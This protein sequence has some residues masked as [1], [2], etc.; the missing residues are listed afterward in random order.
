MKHIKQSL[1]NPDFCWY[2]DELGRLILENV[3][4]HLCKSSMDD[5]RLR[6]HPEEREKAKSLFEKYGCNITLNSD[7]FQKFLKDAQ[8]WFGATLSGLNCKPC[9]YTTFKK[10][11]D[12]NH[13]CEATYEIYLIAQWIWHYFEPNF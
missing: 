13:T 6:I 5:N 7:L 1:I 10:W 4:R 2:T 8:Y 11:Y 9:D 3:W 12:D